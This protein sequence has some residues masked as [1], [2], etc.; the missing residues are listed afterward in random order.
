[1]HEPRIPPLLLAPRM[2]VG[3]PPEVL[4]KVCYRCR[5]DRP[6]V[7]FIMKS[8]GRPYDM[9]SPCL[10]EILA[11]ATRDGGKKARLAHTATHRICYLCRRTL[12]NVSFTRR[13]KGT[14]FSAC[15]DCNKNVFAHRR[16]ARLLAVG[17]TFT[18]AEWLA[19]LAKHPVC[20]ACKR[21]WE[22]IPLPR[23]RITPVTRDHVIPISKDGPNTISNL[24]PLCYSCNSKK[25]ARIAAVP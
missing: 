10:S 12:P 20:Q 8:N 21:R 3:Y 24:Q 11:M 19:L 23:G 13:S 16:R 14:Y 1:M 4:S 17:G 18:T 6:L 25:C 9:C 15:K 5:V 2:R 22:E 7:L